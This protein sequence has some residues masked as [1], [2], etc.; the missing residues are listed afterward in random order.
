MATQFIQD[1]CGAVKK[2]H[3][4]TTNNHHFHIQNGNKKENQNV[5]RYS[6]EKRLRNK[7]DFN[8]NPTRFKLQL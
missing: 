2:I 3:L 7:L 8:S 4:E 5:I 6:T 1:F